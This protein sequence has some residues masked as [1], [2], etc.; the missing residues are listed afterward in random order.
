MVD[1]KHDGIITRVKTE[2]KEC[3]HEFLL[4]VHAIGIHRLRC[5]KC[6]LEG[7]LHKKTLKIFSDI[8]KEI[9]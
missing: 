1:I 4:E 6:G 9:P 5:V 7:Q 8:I 2:K 3:E